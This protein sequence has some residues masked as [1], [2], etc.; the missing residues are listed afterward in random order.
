[1]VISDQNIWFS[2]SCFRPENFVLQRG[3]IK[4]IPEI[5]NFRP[6]WLKFMPYFR[7]TGVKNHTLW[8]CTYLRISFSVFHNYQWPTRIAIQL[9]WKHWWLIE[10][11]FLDEI[12]TNIWYKLQI[13]QMQV[14]IILIHDFHDFWKI[15]KINLLLQLSCANVGG[16]DN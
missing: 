2:V 7:L 14:I 16:C 6:K 1:M 12:K 9:S 3:M 15:T 5:P 10:N 13:K 8:Y 4:K 11:N